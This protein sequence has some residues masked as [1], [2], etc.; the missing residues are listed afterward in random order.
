LRFF[1]VGVCQQLCRGS[2]PFSFF[3]RELRVL[4][5]LNP[6]FLFC[7]HFC[8]G[9]C[10]LSCQ[11]FFLLWICSINFN[12]WLTF[13]QNSSNPNKVPKWCARTSSV[14]SYYL[15]IHC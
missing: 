5:F 9:V 11:G 14:N 1:F 15:D 2:S 4:F 10:Q 13:D 7:C 3:P 6:K 8:F 12:P